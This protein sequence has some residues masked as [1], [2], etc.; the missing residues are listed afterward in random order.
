MESVSIEKYI[1]EYGKDIYSFCMYLTK[2]RFDADDLYQQTF[3]V[4]YEK[5]SIDS[6][7]NPKSYLITIA[8]N[9]WNNQIRKTMWRRKKA[10][11]IQYDEDALER[12]EDKDGSIEEELIDK[13]EKNRIRKIVDTLPDKM[14]IVI[15]MFY[16]EDMSIEDI[17]AALKI[18]AGTVKSRLFKAKKI[19]KEKMAYE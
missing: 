4:A 1:E 13:E 5:G 2:N 14:R 7:K 18:P 12:I 6:D 3:L 10:D 9:I 16:M 15:L 8:V 11:I 17:A 19:L